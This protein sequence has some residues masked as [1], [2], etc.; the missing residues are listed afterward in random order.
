[1]IRKARIEDLQRITD[2]YNQSIRHGFETAHTEEL[3]FS[4]RT[5]WFESHTPEH[6]PLYVYESGGKVTGWISISPYRSGRRA[7]RFTVE[8]SYYVD[9]NFRKQGIGKSLLEFA[10][11]SCE[12]LG[13]RTLMA[14][15]LDRNTASVSLLES[16]GFSEW[17]H[18]P[19]VADFE[20]LKCGHLYFG[21]STAG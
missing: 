10:V 5:E 9:E 16:C 17:G 14:I 19:D 18:L 3:E 7:L 8:L 15:V 6:Y 11:S 12:E 2:I 21:L 4:N 1:M 20:G 13:Y